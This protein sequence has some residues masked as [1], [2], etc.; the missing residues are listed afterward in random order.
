MFIFKRKINVKIRS[1]WILFLAS[2]AQSSCED[3]F[4]RYRNS[5]RLSFNLLDDS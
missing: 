5:L 3:F 2:G 1:G 4:L